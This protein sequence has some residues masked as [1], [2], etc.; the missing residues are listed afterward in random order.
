MET[1]LYKLVHTLVDEPTP[2]DDDIGDSYGFF[3]DDDD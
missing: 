3:T 2:E 1:F